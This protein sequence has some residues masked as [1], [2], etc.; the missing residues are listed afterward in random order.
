[1]ERKTLVNFYFITFKFLIKFPFQIQNKL[2]NVTNVLPGLVSLKPRE[3]V[4]KELDAKAKQ[5]FVMANIM[6]A[7]NFVEILLMILVDAPLLNFPWFVFFSSMYV[8]Y[9]YIQGYYSTYYDLGWSPDGCVPNSFDKPTVAPP[10]KSKVNCL[11]TNACKSAVSENYGWLCFNFNQNTVFSFTEPEEIVECDAC[12]AWTCVRGGV[13]YAGAGCKE[14]KN[15]CDDN[16][17]GYVDNKEYFTCKYSLEIPG[18]CAID[19]LLFVCCLMEKI[20]NG[21]E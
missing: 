15:V 12:A 11:K 1:M 5:I 14:D 7:A 19:D 13:G 6:Q 10:Q 3:L 17:Q 16:G 21:M 8:Y 20:I 9:W 4:L 2:L 18:R